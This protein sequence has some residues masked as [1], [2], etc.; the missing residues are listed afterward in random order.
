MSRC[1]SAKISGRYA[2]LRLSKIAYQKLNFRQIEMMA[3]D[4]SAA[5]ILAFYFLSVRRK[6]APSLAQETE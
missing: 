4:K 5:I 2:R 3:A 1:M 6:S